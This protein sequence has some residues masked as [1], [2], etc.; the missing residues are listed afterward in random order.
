MKVWTLK[1]IETPKGEV[2]AGKM[3]EIPPVILE[4]LKGKVEAV[5]DGREKVTYCLVT[6][7]WC[8]ARLPV[9]PTPCQGCTPYERK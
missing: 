8:T 5:T 2:P 4:K 3:V 9:D 7:C 6:R 1:T